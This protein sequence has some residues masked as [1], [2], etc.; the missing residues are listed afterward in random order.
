ML[1]IG[2]VLVIAVA[3]AAQEHRSE[4]W[5]FTFKNGDRIL[6]TRSWYY[7]HIAADPVNDN[8]VYVLNAPFMKSIDGGV[9]FEKKSTPHGDHHD[10]WINPHNN[11]N[12]INANDGGATITFDGGESWSSINNQPT[13]QF[14]RVNTD[15]QFPYRVYAGQQDNS[16]VSILSETYDSGIGFDD[17]FSVGGGESAH[18]AFDPDNPKLIYATTINGTLTELDVDTRREREIKPYPEFVFGMDSKDLRYRANWNAPVT[19]SPQDP[20]VIYYGAQMVL[21]GDTSYCTPSIVSVP[22]PDSTWMYSSV[23]NCIP[24]NVNRHCWVQMHGPTVASVNP[25]SS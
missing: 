8:I 13:A 22:E 23:S 1:R 18:I 3:A 9:T 4:R 21:P 25:H 2:L 15:N 24:A 20:S 5:R 10:H 17:F 14:Y 11:L 16:T 6:W 12:M 19:A 7:Q